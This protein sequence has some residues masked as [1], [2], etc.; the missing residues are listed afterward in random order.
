ME[1][2]LQGV[3]TS[4]VNSRAKE[5]SCT[6]A[7][8]KTAACEGSSSVACAC[9]QTGL[10]SVQ[11]DRRCV[12]FLKTKR[13]FSHPC[14]AAPS[15]VFLYLLLCTEEKDGRTHRIRARTGCEQAVKLR[16]SLSLEVPHFELEQ[17]QT[18]MWHAQEWQELWL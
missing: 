11:L 16:T 13:S 1:D 12:I 14:T 8:E 4:A 9:R 15:R 18:T 17:Q 5:S 10:K 2:D 3:G 7:E 6:Q